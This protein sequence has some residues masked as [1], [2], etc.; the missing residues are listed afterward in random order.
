VYDV[1]I[2]SIEEDQSNAGNDMLV[3]VYE[4]EDGDYKGARIWDYITF[5][6]SQ[7]WKLEQF[8]YAVG[9]DPGDDY[10][11]DDDDLVGTLVKLRVRADSYDGQYRARAGQV[12]RHPDSTAARPGGSK[13]IDVETETETEDD[14]WPTKEEVEAMSIAELRELAEELELEDI[15]GKRKPALVK[16]IVSELENLTF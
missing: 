3:V 1:K 5:T 11:I 10:S 14:D 2:H 12:S 7:A 9:I 13:V 16:L 8:L 6:D 4:L 15:S